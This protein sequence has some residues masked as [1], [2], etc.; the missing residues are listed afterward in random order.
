MADYIDR[1]KY[2]AEICR[3]KFSFCDKPC[4]Q[5]WKAP[6]ADVA[7]VGHGYWIEDEGETVCSEC[8]ES[9]PH[10]ISYE[11]LFGYDWDENLVP[12]GYEKHIEHVKTNY[13]S[14][15]GAKMDGGDT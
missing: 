13:C 7:E 5:I 14:N 1:E 10:E 12:C 6:A 11:E 4:C 9:A 3:C 15:C 8:K 2:C